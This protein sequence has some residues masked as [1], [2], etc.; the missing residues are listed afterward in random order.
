[1]NIEINVGQVI[2]TQQYVSGRGHSTVKQLEMSTRSKVMVKA[3]FV[4]IKLFDY[5]IIKIILN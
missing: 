4:Y 1:M 5:I 2:S 3:S